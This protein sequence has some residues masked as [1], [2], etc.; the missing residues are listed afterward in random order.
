M[1][2]NPLASIAANGNEGALTAPFEGEVRYPFEKDGSTRCGKWKRGSQDY[3]YFGAPRNNNKR[4]HAGID[5]YPASGAGTA[6]KAVKNG[7]VIKIAP[8]YIRSNGEVTYAVLV[9]HGDFTVNYAEL[10]KPDLA[11]SSRLEKGQIIGNVSG[12]AQLHFELYKS[13]TTEWTRGWYGEKPPNLL[14]PTEFVLKLFSVS[15][16]SV[17]TAEPFKQQI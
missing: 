8:F 13:G 9:D 3:P 10:K 14:D 7:L 6:V 11:V 16:A 12:T 1:L 5:I 15:K 4:N 2:I 17:R